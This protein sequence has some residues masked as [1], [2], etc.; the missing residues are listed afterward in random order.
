MDAFLASKIALYSSW[1]PDCHDG[2]IPLQRSRIAAPMRPMGLLLPGD[3][4][5]SPCK[6]GCC[7]Q[8]VQAGQRTG[9][10]A[11]F[12]VKASFDLICFDHSYV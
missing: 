12:Q 9:L 8:S 5:E 10:R 4:S 2:S 11:L 7:D 3:E 1:R 6:R